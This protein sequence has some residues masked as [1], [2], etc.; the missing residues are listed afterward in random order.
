MSKT[1]AE[2]LSDR[3]GIPILEALGIDPFKIGRMVID[4]QPGQPARVYAEI[5]GNEKLLEVDWAEALKGIEVKFL[6]GTNP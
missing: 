3:V 2:V 6:G 5:P 1:G 4:L